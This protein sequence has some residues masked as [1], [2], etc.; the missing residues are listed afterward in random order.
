LS[1]D[2]ITLT[3]LARRLRYFPRTCEVLH[4]AR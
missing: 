4:L 3:S 2:P 1:L